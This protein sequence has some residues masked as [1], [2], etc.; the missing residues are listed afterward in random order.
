MIS[1]AV[2]MGWPI[3]RSVPVRFTSPSSMEKART[4]GEKVRSRSNT[5]LENSL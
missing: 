1:F 5:F 2:R 4:S 3:R